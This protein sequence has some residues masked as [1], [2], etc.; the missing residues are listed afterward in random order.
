MQ[1]AHNSKTLKI[2]FSENNVSAVHKN[3]TVVSQVRTKEKK[4][5]RLQKVGFVSDK[6]LNAHKSLSFIC[7]ATDVIPVHIILS[8]FSMATY[9]F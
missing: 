8:S 6:R 2:T 5:N 7:C 3:Y 4:A 9:S 1:I